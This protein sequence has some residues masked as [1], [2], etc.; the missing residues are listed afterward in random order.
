MRLIDTTQIELL[1]R[2]SGYFSENEEIDQNEFATHVLEQP[3]LVESFHEY[4]SEYT[5]NKSIEIEDNFQTSKPAVKQG[6]KMF[7]SVLKLDKNFHIYVHGNQ[8]LIESGYDDQRGMKYYK[9]FYN[10]EK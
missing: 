7:K 2:S 5:Q 4:K 6:K 8:D 9:V 3:D 1:N 10:E